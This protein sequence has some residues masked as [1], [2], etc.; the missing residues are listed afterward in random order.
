MAQNIMEKTNPSGSNLEEQLLQKG[1]GLI[2]INRSMDKYVSPILDMNVSDIRYQSLI[3]SDINAS[4]TKVT[5]IRYQCLIFSDINASD[6]NISNMN[7][8]DM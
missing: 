6:V 4:D 1:L 3:V 7:V 2:I 5:D 8:S